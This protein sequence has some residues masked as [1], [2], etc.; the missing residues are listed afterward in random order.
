MDVAL[1]FGACSYPGDGGECGK[2]APVLVTVLESA[3]VDA[4]FELCPADAIKVLGDWLIAGPGSA[5][6]F[7]FE[8]RTVAKLPEPADPLVGQPF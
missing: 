3:S 4:V 7:S 8:W 2:P 1:E 5:E 6:G